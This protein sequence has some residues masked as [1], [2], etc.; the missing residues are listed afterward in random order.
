MD[1]GQAKR[2]HGNILQLNNNENIVTGN[3]DGDVSG[4][5]TSLHGSRNE[6]Y[7]RPWGFDAV[8]Q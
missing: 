1:Y 8:V 3:G 2:L 6:P 4:L 7:A 5:K